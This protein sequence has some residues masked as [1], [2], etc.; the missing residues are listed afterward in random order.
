MAV[1]SV[2]STSCG[3]GSSYDNGAFIVGEVTSAISDSTIYIAEYAALNADATVPRDLIVERPTLHS[4]GFEWEIAG[5]DNNNAIVELEYRMEGTSSWRRGHDLLR[6]ENNYYPSLGASTGNKLAGSAILL[7][8]GTTY[9]FR[10][11]LKDS[12][13]DSGNPDSVIE[14]RTVTTTTR[15]IPGT[16]ASADTFYVIPGSG[17]GSGTESDPFRGLAEADANAQPGNIY[18]LKKGT[19]TGT[20]TLLKNGTID[21]PIIYRG[22][23]T[24]EV[25]MDGAG[26]SR[27]IQMSY[28]KH[29]SLEQMTIK[30][31]YMLVD[32][33]ASKGCI[34]R[35]LNLQL[36]K[37]PDRSGSDGTMIGIYLGGNSLDGYICDNTIFGDADNWPNLTTWQRGIHVNGQ[38]HVICYN[39][40]SYI[41]GDGISTRLQSDYPVRSLDIYNNLIHNNSD[42]GIEAD[43]TLH[44]IRIYRNKVYNFQS[45]ISAQPSYA[46]PTYIFRNELI[47]AYGGSTFKLNAYAPRS[48]WECTNGIYVLHNTAVNNNVGQYGSYWSNTT[49]R[50]NLIY[51]DA[52]HALRNDGPPG[53]A[54]NK[55]P[56]WGLPNS[57]DYNGWH[58]GLDILI[59]LNFNTY[60]TLDEFYQETGNEAHGLI[61]D[62]SE[63]NMVQPLVENTSYNEDDF[64]FTLVAGARALDNAVLI[65]G[66]NDDVLDG[67]PDMGA[68]ERGIAA[69]TYGPR[70]EACEP[71]GDIIDSNN[72]SIYQLCPY[73]GPRETTENWKSH[74]QYVSCIAQSAESFVRMGLI[75]EAE[76]DIIIST[77]ANSSY[78]RKKEAQK[79][80]LPL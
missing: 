80:Q 21:N 17:G 71:S 70:S 13:N 14:Q 48:G 42:D 54:N 10:L 56:A 8:P 15:D 41:G 25:I 74:G 30:N 67:N 75:T 45:G 24:D 69:P 72:C 66:L 12:D 47:N 79:K 68:L 76:K 51:G 49:F 28:R 60:R 23:D 43:N 7:E 2:F 55:C 3:G 38:G 52:N 73:E 16:Y 19:Y 36:G 27:V 11:T 6:T 9:V 63:F 46:G 62:L 26:E 29:V 33:D 35:N 1:T 65:P 64:D 5:D 59:N 78:G 22:E 44:N 4:V 40:I 18:V 53:S 57:Y 20:Q 61:F 77:A 50:N 39:H 34:F 32:A 31:A 37:T 58:S